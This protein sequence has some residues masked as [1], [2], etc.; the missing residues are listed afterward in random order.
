M[1]ICRSVKTSSACASSRANL[2]SPSNNSLYI[3][4]N[5]SGGM[6]CSSIC[7]C[8]SSLSLTGSIEKY[9]LKLLWLSAKPIN[10]SAGRMK[11]TTSSIVPLTTIVQRRVDTRPLKI[12][13]AFSCC[14][15]LA[16]TSFERN[17]LIQLISSSVP[18]AILLNS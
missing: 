12:K 11:T 3:V 2:I 9:G 1:P 5:S 18:A 6:M 13:L 8:T 16:V 10:L 15:Q 14:C 7:Q 4:A 17:G